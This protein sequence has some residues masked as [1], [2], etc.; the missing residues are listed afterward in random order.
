MHRREPLSSG[1]V[2]QATLLPFPLGELHTVLL[3][4]RLVT[5]YMRAAMETHAHFTEGLLV[6]FK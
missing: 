2:S 6:M 1:Y 4:D 5:V 3:M